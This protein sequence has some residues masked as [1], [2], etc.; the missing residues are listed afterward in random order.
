MLFRFAV[1][2]LRCHRARCASGLSTNQ[3]TLSM[4]LFNSRRSFLKASLLT[5]LAFLRPENAEANFSPEEKPAGRLNLYNIHTGE[6]ISTLY[7]D[8]DGQYNPQAITELNWLLRCHH[9]DQQHPIDI[10]TLDFLDL[11]N[12]RVGCNTEIHVISGYRSPEYND[13]LLRLG[14]KVAKNSLHLVGRALDIR[15]PGTALSTLHRTA[16]SLRIGG[17][18]YYPSE[19]FVHIDSGAFRTW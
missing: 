16:L 13:R 15:I 4:H 7:R 9:T 1:L 18:G 10:Q 3:E 8:R 12:S 14:H 2:P 6:R 19:D 5:T 17:V 11:L